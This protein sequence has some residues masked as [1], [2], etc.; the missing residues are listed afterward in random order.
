VF[1]FLKKFEFYFFLIFYLIMNQQEIDRKYLIVVEMYPCEN[2][3]HYIYKPE[4]SD[5]QIKIANPQINK[6]LPKLDINVKY[7]DNY[8]TVIYTYKD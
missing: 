4:I 1:I 2:E 6:K 8:T 7:R 3:K 5:E